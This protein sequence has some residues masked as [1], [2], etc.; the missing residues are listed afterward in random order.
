MKTSYVILIFI[1][2]G[3]LVALKIKAL[4]IL[5][6]FLF[7]IL[8]IACSTTPSQLEHALQLA[9]DN[10]AELEKTLA[11]YSANPADSLKYRAASCSCSTIL[12]ADAKSVHLRTKTKNRYGGKKKVIICSE[13]DYFAIFAPIQFARYACPESKERT[14]TNTETFPK[15]QER[16]TTNTGTFPKGQERTTTNTGTFP[17]G[18]ERTNTNTET[19]PKGQER[20]TTDT[21]T[22]PIGREK[23]TT[24]TEF[25]IRNS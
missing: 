17:K 13:S 12:P 2:V 3:S 9:G 10:R 23:T 19:F 14:T 22:F 6:V 24:N 25:T 4:R 21:E 11:H 18:Q 16:T 20:T 8:L 7:P 5:F 15:G 1:V